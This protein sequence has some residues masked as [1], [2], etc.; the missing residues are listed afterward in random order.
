MFLHIPQAFLCRSA[1]NLQQQAAGAG[2]LQALAFTPTSTE[3]ARDIAKAG[4]INRL[5]AMLSHG[6]VPMRCAAAGTLCNLS[7]ACPAN[8]VSLPADNLFFFR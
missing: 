6:P 4:A 8:Q 2:A 3:L 7:L 5:V 1:G